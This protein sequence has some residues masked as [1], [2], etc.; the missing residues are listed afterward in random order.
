VLIAD[1]HEAIRKGVRTILRSRKDLEICGEASNGS[2]AVRMAAEL[3]PDLI[4]LDLT[5][6]VMGGFA[7]AKELRQLLPEIPIL[8]YSMH[9]GRQLIKEAKQAGARGF[10]SKSRISDTLLDA[11]DAVVVRNGTFFPD[12]GGD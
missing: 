6:P 1:D 2:E 8:F 7:A 10:V 12:G 3:S 4:I 9:D 11:V 5:M